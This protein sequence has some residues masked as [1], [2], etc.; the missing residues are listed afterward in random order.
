MTRRRFTIGIVAVCI[1]VVLGG[2]GMAE[3]VWYL[4]VHG[5]V[6]SVDDQQVFD[7]RVAL[8]GK[9][10]GV[11]AHGVHVQFIGANRSIIK[12]I[13]VGQLNGTNRRENITVRLDRKPQYVRVVAGRIESPED[14]RHSLSGLELTE[15]G[16]YRPYYQNTTTTTG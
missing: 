13:H 4:S 16:D 15:D 7:G 8:E 10:G 12:S 1:M 2:C 6:E 14:A 5:D 9:F 11:T 3:Q